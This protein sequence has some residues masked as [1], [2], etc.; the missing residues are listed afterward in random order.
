VRRVAVVVPA[1]DERELLPACLAA[2]A[3]AAAEVAPL[4]VERIVVADACT[5]DT[6][7]LAAA[8]GATVLTIA[9]RNVGAARAAGMAQALR[10]GPGGLWLATTDADS[11]VSPGWLRWQLRHAATG[12]D[13][14]AGT[15]EVDDWTAWPAGLPA[16]Y[17]QRYRAGVTSRAHRH[18]H[19]ANL[20]LTAHAYLAAGGFAARRFDEDRDLIS[21]ALAT[22]ARVVADPGCPV[23]TSSRPHGRAPNGFAA[24]LSSLAAEAIRAEA[25]GIG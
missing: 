13:L 14:L 15:V 20:G 22:G 12:A 21:R 6:A 16:A 17:E 23:R 4:P 8:A 19:G 9:A 10:H 25:V 24:H 11:L 3:V 18:V 1:H 7:A 2:I 5:D